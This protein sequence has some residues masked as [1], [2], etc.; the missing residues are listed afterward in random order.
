MVGPHKNKN[1]RFQVKFTV[2]DE[3]VK[4][5][6]VVSARTDAPAWPDTFYLCVPLMHSGLLQ[7][8]DWCSYSY[9]RDISTLTLEIYIDHSIWKDRCVGQVKE[10]LGSLLSEESRYSASAVL[11]S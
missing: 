6:T 2:D 11:F 7:V 8:N 9:A 5:K 4:R 1:K 10:T 3:K